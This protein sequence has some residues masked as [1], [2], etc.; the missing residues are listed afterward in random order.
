M[1]EEYTEECFANALNIGLYANHNS[2]MIGDRDKT[3]Y[4]IKYYA[5]LHG[6]YP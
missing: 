6:L 1:I 3:V 2:I 5:I 4:L